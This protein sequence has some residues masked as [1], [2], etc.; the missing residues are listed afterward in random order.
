MIEKKDKLLNKLVK[1]DYNNLLE[2][3]LETKE[4]NENVKSLILSMSYKIETA[5]KDYEKVKKNVLSKEEYMKNIFLIIQ[6]KCDDINFIKQD[7]EIKEKKESIDK[8]KK[9]IICYPIER[10]VL[11]AIFRIEKEDN[12]VKYENS[13]IRKALTNMLNEGNII[14]MSEPLR[15]FNGFSWNIVA[16]DIKN[17]TYNLVYQNLIILNGYIFLEK[18]INNNKFVINYLEDFQNDIEEKYGEN[19]RKKI[20]SNLIKISIL[21]GIN[22]DEHFKE[23]VEKEK[24]EIELEYSKF[25]ESSQYLTELGNK[26]KLLAK[27][28][29]KI[30]Q[31]INDK[32]LLDIEYEKRNEKLPLE[33]KIFSMRVLKKMMQ[34]ERE[35]MIQKMEEYANLMNPQVFIKKYEEISENLEYFKI[36]ESHDIEKTI[37]D[38]IMELQKNILEAFEIKINKANEKQ[39]VINLIYEL[40][41]YIQVPISLEKRIYQEENLEEDLKKIEKL[42]IEK[43]IAKKIIIEVSNIDEINLEVLRNLFKSTII[44]LET[45]A[46]K[47][48]KE[49]EIWKVQFF[50]EEIAENTIDI[51]EGLDKKDFKIRLN[52]NAKLFI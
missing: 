10:N 44:S 26:K 20:I 22:L 1:K 11:E 6:K 39:E 12:I 40:R 35:K 38:N 50:D 15:D 36:I 28:I 42:L 37:F 13:V 9:Q 51:K 2:E 5:Y 49:E 7:T 52:K 21:E 47:V 43:A 34:E 24:T 48:F 3:L 23:E 45:I 27:R 14:N 41:Y 30:D 17:L 33:K 4:Y 31:T 8:S 32:E 46:I 19:L 25:K 29:R 16:R 18:W